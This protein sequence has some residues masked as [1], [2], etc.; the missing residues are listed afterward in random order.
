MTTA[1][2][3][4]AVECGR[5]SENLVPVTALDDVSFV[6][7]R[8]SEVTAL[9]GENGAGKSTLLKILAGL[10]PPSSGDRSTSSD[11]A[12]LKSSTPNSVLSKHSVAIV[13]QELSLIPD[14]TVAENILAG[15][16][17]G[18][19]LFPSKRQL[20]LHAQQ[21][22][23]KLNLSVS[24]TTMAG[25]LDMATQQLV[26]VARAVAQECRVLILDEPTSILTPAESTRLF[27][28]VEDLRAKGTTV[29]YVSHR[30]PEVFALSQQ[31]EVLRDG[32]H[33]KSA[34]TAEITSEEAVSSMVGRDLQAYERDMDSAP[35]DSIR[36]A[37]QLHDLAGRGHEDVSFSVRPG[38]IVGIAGLPDS[39]RVELIS[40]VYGSD[41]GKSGTVTLL[42]DS[43][44]QRSPARSIGQ[45]MTLLPGERK[46][47]AVMSEMTVGENIGLLRAKDFSVLGFQQKRKWMREA[48][49]LATEWGVKTSSIDA[50]I[51]SL[52]GGNQQEGASGALPVGQ[53]PGADPR[54]ADSRSRCR[55]Q[56][57]H[58]TS[59]SQQWRSRASRSCAHRQTFLSCWPLQ[60]G[61][62]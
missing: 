47:Q 17:P 40:N 49:E 55:R 23:E 54:R 30:M 15:I 25:S 31:I 43:Y 44:D 27:T 35:D 26:V 20:N 4:A 60:T 37:L 48:Q 61:S 50:P 46:A 41:T 5:H 59:A 7:V 42:G 22:L 10:Q 19:K 38:E 2:S 45:G 14:R 21:V 12:Q 57:G 8:E 33:V 18:S 1:D 36:P 32:R 24:P 56:G 6:M 13:P 28:L 52:S 29:L 9:L 34:R 3:H 11:R 16:E 58:P 39:G 62:S 53:A 51:S